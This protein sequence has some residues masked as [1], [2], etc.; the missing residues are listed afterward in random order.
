MHRICIYIRLISPK[1]VHV[2]VHNK[3]T[4][5]SMGDTVALRLSIRI[6]RPDAT[7][8]Q[9]VLYTKSLF[10]RNTCFLPEDLKNFYLTT[11]GYKLTWCVKMDSKWLAGIHLRYSDRLNKKISSLGSTCIRVIC[12]LLQYSI[13]SSYFNIC[14]QTFR[15]LLF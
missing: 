9:L 12:Y 13:I 2:F 1:L 6:F 7:D 4:I 5:V 14:K 11:D 10:Q 15:K 3:Y 8:L